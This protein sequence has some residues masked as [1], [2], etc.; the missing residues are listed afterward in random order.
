MSKTGV[1]DEGRFVV[2]GD[3]ISFSGIKNIDLNRGN[4]KEV[5]LTK[6]EETKME[7]VRLSSESEAMSLFLDFISKPDTPRTTPRAKL[8]RQLT[9]HLLRVDRVPSSSLKNV[10]PEGHFLCCA[11]FVSILESFHQF[12]KISEC[13]I[14]HCQQI[15]NQLKTVFLNINGISDIVESLSNEIIPDK[16]LRNVNDG[17]IMKD[18]CLLDVCL[19]ENIESAEKSMYSTASS[20]LLKQLD[21]SSKIYPVISILV[22]LDKDKWKDSKEDTF[23]EIKITGYYPTSGDKRSKRNRNRK[24]IKYKI[25]S[26]N[27]ISF[28]ITLDTISRMNQTL[29]KYFSNL[30][31]EKDFSLIR[32]V[33]I[34]NGIVYKYFKEEYCKHPELAVQFI[35]NCEILFNTRVL[36]YNFISGSHIPHNI[37]QLVDI[38]IQL[39]D[40]HELNIC[41]GDIRLS[42]MIFS[43]PL[44]SPCGYCKTLTENI[45][46][47]K[48]FCSDCGATLNY[49]TLIDFD[50]SGKENI[51]I[52]PSTFNCDIPDSVRHYDAKPL[53]SLKKEHDLYS[54]RS[55]IS[56]FLPCKDSNINL[57]NE[58]IFMCNLLDGNELKTKLIELKLDFLI[59]LNDEKDS[60]FGIKNACRDKYQ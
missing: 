22:I 6:K 17:F 32:N 54:I 14:S 4:G 29:E 56:W 16:L 28:S 57:W 60:L 1:Y 11:Q 27:I 55:I 33:Y 21:N 34:R 38:I 41:H 9:D 19:N 45:S 59:R 8:K 51:D 18:I 31:Q 2:D 13:C 30:K 43:D 49:T 53:A 3:V 24:K 20:N 58:F 23:G 26:A 50:L 52:Y 40:I 25:L 42:N 12:P 39:C 44:P 36:K 47:T 15:I 37:K 5:M 46:D 48:Y 7:L 10:K 35:P